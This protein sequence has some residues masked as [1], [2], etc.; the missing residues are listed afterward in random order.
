MF[1]K[2]YAKCFKY[3][4]SINTARLHEEDHHS[5]LI[6]KKFSY[7]ISEETKTQWIKLLAKDQEARKW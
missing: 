1:L 2:N 4:I 3:T 7:L 5:Y 6:N